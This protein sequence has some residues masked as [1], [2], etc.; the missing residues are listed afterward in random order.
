MR[1]SSPVGARELARGPMSLGRCTHPTPDIKVV[2]VL[3]ARSTGRGMELENPKVDH[4]N[5]KVEAM[6]KDEVRKRD[7]KRARTQASDR[8]LA[9]LAQGGGSQLSLGSVATLKQRMRPRST[10]VTGNGGTTEQQIST[11]IISAPP[12]LEAPVGVAAMGALVSEQSVSLTD[13]QAW[14]QFNSTA[15]L[16]DLINP[17]SRSS[18]TQ[19]VKGNEISMTSVA[20]AEKFLLNS[21]VAKQQERARRLREESSRVC[22]VNYHTDRN[23]YSSL[24]RITA[25]PANKQ[26]QRAEIAKMTPLGELYLQNP[27]TKASRMFAP[28]TYDHVVP[29]SYVSAHGMSSDM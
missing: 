19:P 21:I 28:A 14:E 15:S 1:T 12:A 29:T 6:L 23:P 16:V 5:G 20:G 13:S 26:K 3:T 24:K 2:G 27:T 9:A 11:T 25:T 17:N 18:P 4:L 22:Q 8:S 7:L 10:I